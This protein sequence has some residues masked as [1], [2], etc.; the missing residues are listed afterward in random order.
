MFITLYT[1]F[2]NTSIA[3]DYKVVH[4]KKMIWT[5]VLYH[6]VCNIITIYF[7]FS[8]IKDT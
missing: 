5:V 8:L 7:A 2:L 6:I 4:N 3:F 1:A